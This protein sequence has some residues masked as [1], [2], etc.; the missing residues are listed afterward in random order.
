MCEVFIFISLKSLFW[1][2]ILYIARFEPDEA[3]YHW[4]VTVMRQHGIDYQMG[5]T[6]AFS[7]MCF[8]SKNAIKKRVSFSQC[9][10]IPKMT[11][12]DQTVH[13]SLLLQFSLQF[14]TVA[15]WSCLLNCLLNYNCVMCI[16]NCTLF[17][18]V[19]WW[20]VAPIFDPF[21][22]YYI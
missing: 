21:L 9:I 10:Y 7:L 13:Y 14:L 1:Y 15:K 18:E 12:E 8:T 3:Y 6:Y 2:N 11:R 17:V 22:V 4:L 19:T 5:H 20:G 16:H